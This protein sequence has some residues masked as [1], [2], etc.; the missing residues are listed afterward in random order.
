M[1]KQGNFRFDS[2]YWD[3]VSPNA[4]DLVSR[5]LQVDPA[6]RVTADEVLDHPWITGTVGSA[7]LA[8]VRN[9]LMGF[10]ARKRKVVKT[11]LLVK[12]G[13][14]IHS[15]R[16]RSFVLY[17]DSLEYYEP[18]SFAPKGVV[19]LKDIADVQPMTRRGAFR[20]NTIQRRV[21]IVQAQDEAGGRDWV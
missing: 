6:R 11:G 16:E 12:R 9:Q 3:A 17:G 18:D 7:Q 20:I 14:I 13:Q 8:G 10:E 2:P 15:W 4:K 1:I 21:L 5:M 19:L